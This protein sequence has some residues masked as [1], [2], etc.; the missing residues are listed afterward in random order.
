MATD[1]FKKNMLI[2]N[3]TAVPNKLAK[4][5]RS[6]TACSQADLKKNARTSPIATG[7][8]NVN[9]EKG[10]TDIRI[11][12]PN[13]FPSGTMAARNFIAVVRS[14][15][16]KKTN[17]TFTNAKVKSHATPAGNLRLVFLQI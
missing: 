17:A 8:I 9:S 10:T 6:V 12:V 15:E 16:R 3:S 7:R 14:G 11:D 5:T 1:E 2:V 13:T 4:V